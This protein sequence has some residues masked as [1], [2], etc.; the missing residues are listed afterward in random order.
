[1]GIRASE[2]TQLQIWIDPKAEVAYSLMAQ[3]RNGVWHY[4][5]GFK[6]Y[7]PQSYGWCRDAAERYA[8]IYHVRLLEDRTIEK[9]VSETLT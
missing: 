4:Y 9:T 5:F 8:G 7:D 6:T 1:M 3:D 2:I